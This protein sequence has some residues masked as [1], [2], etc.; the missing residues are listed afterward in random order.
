L[1][2]LLMSSD[3]TK[4]KAI[5]LAASAVELTTSAPADWARREMKGIPA[6]LGAL[7]IK[8]DGDSFRYAIQLDKSH[9]NAQGF[10]HGGVLMTFVDHALSLLIWEASG[11]AMCSTVHLDS[12][13]LKAVRPPAFI[14]LDGKILRQGKSTAFARG[15][16]RV[17]GVDVMEATGV[18][19][20]VQPNKS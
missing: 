7:W 5:E 15:T 4:A 3:D 12:H 16:L 1:Q 14:E 6:S 18:W 17:D 9:A 10:V 11:R 2:E 13:F 20:I 8:R 19:S